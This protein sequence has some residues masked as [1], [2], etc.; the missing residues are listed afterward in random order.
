MINYE[1]RLGKINIS[2]EY[3]SKLIGN[4]VSS[5][6]GVVGMAPASKR[7]RLFGLFSKKDYV[8][9]GIIVKG[10]TDSMSVELHILVSYGMNINA[11]AKSIVHKVKFVIGESTGIAVKK[12]TVKVDGIKE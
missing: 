3:L 1:T 5:C 6:Y 12:V 8:D 7:Q 4:A 11:I 9:K 2:Y 10:D